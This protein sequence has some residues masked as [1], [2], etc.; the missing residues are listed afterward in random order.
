MKAARPITYGSASTSC[1][2]IIVS[3]TSRQQMQWGK[4]KP[5]RVAEFQHKLEHLYCDNDTAVHIFQVGKGRDTVLQGCARQL[6]L[7][8]AF[9]DITLTVGHIPGKLLTSSANA[10]S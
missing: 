4:S 6:W 9:H 10:L 1:E 8:C 5:G 3:A 2:M 7:T